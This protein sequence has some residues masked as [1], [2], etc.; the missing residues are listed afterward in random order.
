M[1]DNENEK[2]APK[3]AAPPEPKYA[4]PTPLQPS[5]GLTRRQAVRSMMFGTIGAYFGAVA[6]GGGVMFWPAKVHGFGAPVKAGKPSDIAVGDIKRVPEGKCFLSRPD[7]GHLI[8]LY[9]TCV[10]LGCTVPW[11]ADENL[12]HCPCHG[13]MYDK[14]GKNVG[15][16][17]PRPLDYMDI[18][19]DK[20]TGEIIVNTSKINKRDA[21][22]PKQLTPIPK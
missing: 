9:W 15:G 1:S 7:E 19:F 4:P 6:I 21:Y 10:H 22:D 20:A 17:A 18:E 12:F 14:T 5:E 3:S 8:A 2:A 13:S 11:N 16:P